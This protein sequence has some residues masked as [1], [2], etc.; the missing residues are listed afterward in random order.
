[1]LTKLPAVLYGGD[2]NPDQWPEDVWPEDMRLFRA[3]GVNTVTLP[4]FSWAKLQP[5][6]NEYS[7]G[8]LDRVMELLHKSGIRVIMATPTAAQPAWM[9]HRYPE[10]LPVDEE[11]RRRPHGKRNNY[12]PNSPVYRHYA[13][14][15][16]E[17]LAERY[18]SHPALL[19][20]H[21]NNEYGTRCYCDN[22]AGAFRR[23]LQERY[24][25]V[26][27]LNRRWYLDFWGHTLYGWEEVRVPTKVNQSGKFFPSIAVDYNRFW[28]DSLLQ[29]FRAER[30]VLKRHTPDLPVT[31][32]HYD[33]MKFMDLSRWAE[34]LDIMSFDNYPPHERDPAGTAF[35]L[36]LMRSVKK[37]QPFL[38]MEQTP[39]QQNWQRYNRLK[40]PGVM[41]L[42][43]YQALARGSDSVLFFQMRQSRGA[44]EKYH[45]AV[46]SHAGHENTR[47]FR[48]CAG[49]GEEL[50]RMG[51]AFL[52]AKVEAKA[53]MLF[54][55]DNWVAVEAS[56]GPNADVNY[57]DQAMRYYR[58]L[59]ALNIAV[60]FV[61]PD[62]DLSRYDLLIAPMLYMVKSGLAPKL[63][64]F[65]NAGG[66][67]VTTCFSGY[68]DETDIIAWQGYPGPLRKLL[69][70]WVEELD[71]Q[72][73]EQSNTIRM[74]PGGWGALQGEYGCTMLFDL[75]HPEGAETL[76]VYGGDF[77]AG[78]P[79]LTVNRYGK[80][81]AY[82]VA[83]VPGEPFVQGLLATL[84]EEKGIPG[85]T[86]ACG[87]GVEASVRTR[88]GSSTVFLLN[89]NGEAARV[90]LGGKRFRSLTDGECRSG[91]LVLPP[92]GAAV[93]QEEEGSGDAG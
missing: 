35:K 83:T 5:S 49:L 51:E 30:D 87:P 80:G 67:F 65:V 93:L 61:W 72:P 22:C 16:A 34:H 6:E 31:T 88:E 79:A 78:M 11:G 52:G 13:V 10:V 14:R 32:N 27:E 63:E 91:V 24:G 2:Y 36:D 15:M 62:S 69:G 45:A 12:C 29:V 18:G 44:C 41:R 1:M 53:A 66:T 57:V 85:P 38:L 3:A 92:F 90:E 71:A 89:H 56:S 26:E 39:N 48:E 55:W 20:W 70:V 76:A 37:G 23:W 25:S 54:D 84:C 28:S 4:V 81:R 64:A 77:Y 8:W 73:P 42:M 86:L 82:Y 74:R 21:I 46:I 58:A 7:F 68:V 47:V 40:R 75:L 17:R 60:D 59:Y 50:R 33:I 9:S 43:S 19:L